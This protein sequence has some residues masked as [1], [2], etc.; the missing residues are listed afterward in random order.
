MNLATFLFV[1]NS[2][3]RLSNQSTEATGLYNNIALQPGELFLPAFPSQALLQ[4]ISEFLL[5]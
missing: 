5:P 1:R 3:I 4:S 2:L